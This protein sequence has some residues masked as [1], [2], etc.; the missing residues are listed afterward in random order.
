VEG[1]DTFEVPTLAHKPKSGGVRIWKWR[2]ARIAAGGEF[3][4]EGSGKVS[5]IFRGSRN[6]LLGPDLTLSRTEP[7]KVNFLDGKKGIGNW[8]VSIGKVGSRHIRG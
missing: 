6:K 5:N 3:H 4:N 1:R 2:A 8:R 7:I